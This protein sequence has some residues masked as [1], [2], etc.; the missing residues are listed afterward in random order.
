VICGV[1]KN[2]DFADY[3]QPLIVLADHGPLLIVLAW[4]GR[5]ELRPSE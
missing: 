1:E 2:F 5:S 4:I 3:D